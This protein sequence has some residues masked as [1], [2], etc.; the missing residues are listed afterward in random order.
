MMEADEIA[1]IKGVCWRETCKPMGFDRGVRE[2]EHAEMSGGGYRVGNARGREPFC[3]M[4]VFGHYNYICTTIG[5]YK[6]DELPEQE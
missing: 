5:I 2:R 4:I 1:M 3:K 6:I